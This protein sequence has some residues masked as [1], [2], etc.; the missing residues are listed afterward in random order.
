MSLK[1]NKIFHYSVA[2]PLQKSY[3]QDYQKIL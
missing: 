3:I 2:N 1:L